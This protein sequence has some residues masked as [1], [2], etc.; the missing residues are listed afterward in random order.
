MTDTAA[1]KSAFP[2]LAAIAPLGV[3]SGQ[4]E[5]FAGIH[6][7]APVVLK[8]VKSAS[9]PG[10][11]EE[12]L[13]REIEAAATLNSEYVPKVR[14]HGRRRIGGVERVFVVEDRIDG[15]TLR[16]RLT[17]GAVLSLDEA[18]KLA[19]TLL[20][21]CRDFE[22]Q[23]LVH[24]DIKPS[25]LMV[26]RVGK[27]WVIDFGLVRFLDHD[28][29]TATS[30]H[31][32]PFT[33]GYG[34]PEQMRNRKDEIDS[35]ADLFAIGVVLHEVCSG[36]NYHRRNPNILSVI[37]SV[38]SEDLPRLSLAGD[39]GGGFADLVSALASRYRSRRPPSAA[40]ALRWCAELVPSTVVTKQ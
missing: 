13:E 34:A 5:V 33:P 3:P 22:E 16:D 4:K 36:S 40:E 18:H 28:S 6:N 17:P 20:S 2:E 32:G 12:R 19:M 15:M 25:N 26:D 9:R 14:S 8:L 39:S 21:A 38:E 27:L 1:V 31:F 37:R 10:I 30:D 24:R 11:S 7:G 23:Q 29:L 35:R